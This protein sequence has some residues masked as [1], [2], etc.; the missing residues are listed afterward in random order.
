[1]RASN[2]EM[3]KQTGLRLTSEKTIAEERRYARGEMAVKCP[4]CGKDMHAGFLTIPLHFGLHSVKW[5]DSDV[6]R[7]RIL[8]GDIIYDPKANFDLGIVGSVIPADRCTACCTVVFNYLP[9]D[10]HSGPSP[11]SPGMFLRR[12]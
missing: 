1:M 8:G 5:S 7:H 3:K 4:N 12:A 10:G 9:S 6:P 11:S 2:S